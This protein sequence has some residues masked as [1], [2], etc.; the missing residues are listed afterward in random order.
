VNRPWVRLLLLTT[1]LVVAYVLGRTTGFTDELTVEGIRSL[2]RDAG[3][4]GFFVFLA[5][6]VAGQLF[7]IPG[8]IFVAIAGLA[9]GPILGP[10]AAIL[11]TT[12]SVAV[13]FVL[14]RTI[15]GQPLKNLD[16][17]RFRRLLA[18]LHERPLRSMILIRLFFWALPPVN[19]ALA[20][21]GVRF[22]DYMLAAVI[23]CSP[24]FVVISVAS[25]LGFQLL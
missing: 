17:P 1:I 20:M 7:Y 13:S 18:G 22:A 10:P 8:F 15:G 21:S 6:F 12:I 11:G 2:M 3:S 5:T 19:Y 23:G 16:H 4:A 24:P 14:V 9:Y 25:A